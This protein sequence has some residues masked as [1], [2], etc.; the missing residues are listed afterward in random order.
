M[1]ESV[2][3][4]AKVQHSEWHVV[5]EANVD[6]VVGQL[7]SLMVSL[8]Q[9]F[10][11]MRDLLRQYQQSQQLDAFQMQ[12][13]SFQTRVDAIEKEFAAKTSQAYAQMVGGL[14]QAGSAGFG[15]GLQM[16]LADI[17]RGVDGLSQ[18]IASTQTNPELQA[19]QEGQALAD[20]QHQFS[21]QLLTRSDELL[22]KA[23]KVSSDLR[24]VLAAL[25]QA[26]DRITS[27]VRL[28]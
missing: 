2:N 20:Y 9:L 19:A 10:G 26:H 17:G 4:I 8:G 24:D 15:V 7:N 13:T 11:R 18:A 28:S 27:S 5:N 16:P 6:D 14:L 1:T 3:G 12:V 25:V 22:S 23:S 21:Q